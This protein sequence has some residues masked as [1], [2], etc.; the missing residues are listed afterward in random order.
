MVGL[1]MVSPAFAETGW[2]AYCTTDAADRPT[3]FAAG[4]GGFSGRAVILSAA[5]NLADATEILRCAQ[6]D[7]AA[8]HV[9]PYATLS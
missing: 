5:K 3:A 8:R 2:A 7:E 9:E 4:A 6:N 1:S